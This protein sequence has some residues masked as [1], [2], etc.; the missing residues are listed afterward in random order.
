MVDTS[1]PTAVV[2]LIPVVAA[3]PAAAAIGAVGRAVVR[4]K[5]EKAEKAEAGSVVRECSR[6]ASE[7]DAAVRDLHDIRRRAEQ[8]MQRLTGA[9][10]VEDEAV[11]GQ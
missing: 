8:R 6:I 9:A 11:D 3:V 2:P 1:T 7:H 4:R 5:T 10:I